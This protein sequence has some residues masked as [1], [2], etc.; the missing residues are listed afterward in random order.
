LTKTPTHLPFDRLPIV[1]IADLNSIE[2]GEL[3]MPSQAETVGRFG[4][5][6][7]HAD[8]SASGEA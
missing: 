5:H 4:Q 1:D 3:V 7:R 8:G 2:R 6:A